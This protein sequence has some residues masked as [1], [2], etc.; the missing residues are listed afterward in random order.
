MNAVQND[1]RDSSSILAR[2]IGLP[3]RV[4]V[5][6]TML[7]GLLLGGVLVA[8]MTVLGRMSGHGIF[9][10]SSGLFV[11][12]ALLGLAHGAVLGFFGRP[13]DQTPRDAARAVAR[14]T[15]YS[16]LGAAVAW[17]LTVWVALTSVALY[18]GRLAPQILVGVA[19]IGAL[20]VAVWAI[21]VG[22]R[23]LRNAYARWNDRVLGTAL[24]T[25]SFAALLIILLA[26]RPEFWLVPLR[27]TEVGAVLLAGFATLWIVGPIVTLGLRM[28]R[29]LPGANRSRPATVGRGL[30][31]VGLGLV[32]G[33]VAG[34]LAVPFTPAS[35]V[36][37]TA[38]G[39]LVAL[40]QVLVNETF[41]R[42][43]LLTAVAWLVLRWHGS[44]Q[45]EAAA[46]AV[47]TVALAQVILYLPGVVSTGFPTILAAATFTGV[48]IL[49]PALLFGAVY[50]TRGFTA[51]LVADATAALALLL[52]I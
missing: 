1:L 48:A 8:W 35:A 34:L 11:V 32:V 33:A 12:G 50:W 19:W 4:T 49:V 22:L 18:M 41:L 5:A 3:G 31:D 39:T 15:M 23:A 13:A 52:I 30:T 9:M 14:G 28:I 47:I 42:L 37:G 26:D 36:T 16:V 44:H 21:T 38:G 45:E 25:G 7:G 40:S 6:S 10:T 43:F 27:V 46:F 2:G 29:D 17:L 51:A 20:V 24:V